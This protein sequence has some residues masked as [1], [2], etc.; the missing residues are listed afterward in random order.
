M[1]KKQISYLNAIVI[2]LL[3]FTTVHYT[4]VKLAHHHVLHNIL[5]DT[6]M[7]G[8]NDYKAGLTFIY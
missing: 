3:A 4:D 5:A 7:A 2:Y 8:K 6:I 1:Y